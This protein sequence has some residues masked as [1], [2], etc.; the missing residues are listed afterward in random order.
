MSTR[1]ILNKTS[2]K[3]RDTMTNWTDITQ[4]NPQSGVFSTGSAVMNGGTGTIYQTVW[5]PTARPA[6][7]DTGTK[8]SAID[9]ATRTNTNCYM[10]GVKENIQ[11]EVLGGGSWTWRRICFRLK[12]DTINLA[13]PDPATSPVFRQTSNG[14]MRLMTIDNTVID[15]VTDTIFRGEFSVD[16]T[17]VT[18]AKTHSNRAQIVYDRTRII[19]N[20][21]NKAT[22]RNYKMWH[23]MN[24]SLVY[25]DRESGDIMNPAPFSVEGPAGMGDYYIYDIFQSNV[26]GV[27]DTDVLFFEPQATLY[28]H[29]R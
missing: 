10:R 24:K 6:E 12:G 9:K 16:Y 25:E 26:G 14:M 8:G 21:N 3:K 29:E 20:G 19:N 11:F 27:A 23:A 1:Q 15:R 4:A 28:W 5:C 18:N 2:K 7:D 22:A 17:S 13:N